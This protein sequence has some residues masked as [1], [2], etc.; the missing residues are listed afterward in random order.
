MNKIALWR[1]ARGSNFPDLE[2]VVCD[3]E[4]FGA[5]GIT[6]HPRPDQRH[7]RTADVLSLSTLVRTEYNI[8]GYPTEA[9]LQLMEVVKPHQVTL[10]PDAPDALTSSEGWDTVAQADL[11]RLV[12]SRLQYA[13]CRVSLFVEPIAQQVE[14]AATV[15][16]DR[17]E[18]YTGPYAEHFSTNP[19]AAIA[20]YMQA[21]EVAQ[22][23]GLGINAGHDLNL[24]NLE[25]W[26]QRIPQTLE[27]S[28]GHALWVDALYYGMEN[29]IKLYLRAI[30]RGV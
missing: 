5:Q 19:K 26:C 15:G 14:G 4:R 13:G 10:V 23:N 27:V 25:F 16:A 12:I 17:I 18:F 24:P 7:I 9:F 11:L 20:P 28:I 29:T 22:A 8:E 1:N 21:A 3:C 30:A 2:Q 6:I